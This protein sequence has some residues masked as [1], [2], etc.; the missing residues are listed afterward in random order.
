VSINGVNHYVGDRW[1]D[2]IASQ[3]QN[4][5]RLRCGFVSLWKVRRQLMNIT[6]AGA[7]GARLVRDRRV[8]SFETL[9]SGSLCQR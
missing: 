2:R 9:H 4:A 5:N 7:S 1:N 6:D 3:E 8:T